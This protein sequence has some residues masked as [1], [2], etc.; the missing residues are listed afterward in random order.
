[1]SELLIKKGSIISMDPEIGELACGDI[2]IE[3]G[4]I[5]EVGAELSSPGAEEFDATGMIVMPGLINAHIHAWMTALRGIGGDWA[6]WDFFRTVHKNL[7]TRY[8][9]EDSYISTLMG[10]LNQLNCGTTTIFEWCH[11]NKTPEHSDASIDALFDSGIRAVFGHGTVKPKQK[12]GEPH[13]SEIPHPRE[14][15]ERLRK[16]RL[17]D[18][19]ALVTLAICI[20]GPDY[21]IEEVT[22]K[23][24][25]LAKEL[26]ILSSAHIWG[27]DDRKTKDGYFLLER[28]GLLGPKHNGVHG[29]YLTQD[30]LKLM[31]DCGVSLTATPPVELQTGTGE[32]L[33]ARV[34]D[35]GG[36][37][38]IGSDIEVYVVGDMFHVMRHSLQTARIFENR[39]RVSGR[40]P[41]PE[42]SFLTLDVLKWATINNAHALGLADRIGSLTPGKQADIITIRTDDLN[43]IPANN[44]R[45]IVVFHSYPGN[46]DTVFVAGKKVKE[47]G[48]LHY[49]EAQLAEK[50]QE[51]WKSNRRMFKEAG[52]IKK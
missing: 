12:E 36:R 28:E 25:R 16:G 35:L 22:L 8:N 46:V 40:A 6:G 9:P 34:H 43:T 21:A 38:S 7:A 47:K 42:Q 48:R 1:M 26:D 49:P 32:P 23:D 14:L 50:K 3:D 37:P 15:V 52:L 27:S 29:N 10:S 5:K 17:S 51:L 41:L 4:V 30:E 11:N 44:P 39:H 19:E 20:L 33:T 2:L 13:F 31:V 18:D 24:F 45:E